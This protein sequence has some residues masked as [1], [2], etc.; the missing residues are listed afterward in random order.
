MNKDKKEYI[1]QWFEKAD[2]DL[3]TAQTV[4]E[5]Q[6]LIL[7]TACFHQIAEEIKELV[8]KKTKLI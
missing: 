5:Y 6:P 8:L 4:I 7:D 3:L 2:H 1:L